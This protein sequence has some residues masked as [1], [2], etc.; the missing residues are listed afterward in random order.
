[1][2]SDT[3]TG[4]SFA[5]GDITINGQELA[6]FDGTSEDMYD[7]VANINENVDNV[8]ASAFNTVVA[9][10]AGTGI[11]R[12][13]QVAISVGAIGASGDAWYQP[14][15]TVT[16][17]RSDSMEE[18]VANINAA[19]YDNEVVA[20]INDDGKLVL[21][22]DD[23]ATIRIADISGTDDA[24]DGATGFL[25]QTDITVSAT[26]A[27]AY[28]TGVQGF[29]KISST[30]DTPIEIEAGNLGLSSPGTVG[31]IQNIGFNSTEEDPTGNSYTVIGTRLTDTQVAAT[32]GQHSTTEQADLTLNGVEIYDATLSPASNTFQGKL[33][34]INSFSD[35]TGVVASAYY[36]KSFNTANWTLVSRG[37]I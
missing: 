27:D 36:E 33:D 4:V 34:L 35:E 28:S 7:L 18:M 10:T 11:V 23:G 21:S 31:D 16:L 37:Y 3:V 20:T 32:L 12:A 13:N 22:N 15:R 5:A 26:G 29:L 25:V 1:M 24:Y 17:D 30:D 19:F 9:K 2:T 8:T 6:A 14:A